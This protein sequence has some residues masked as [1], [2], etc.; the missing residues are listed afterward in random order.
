MATFR[1]TG[2]RALIK[3]MDSELVSRSI[4]VIQYTKEPEMFAIVLAVGP[5]SRTRDGQ[6]YIP[7]GVRPGDTVIVT[8]NSGAPVFMNGEA[9]QIVGREDLLAVVD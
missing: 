7:M 1:V 3:R 9:C 6:S 5:G 4:E 2:A 8:K